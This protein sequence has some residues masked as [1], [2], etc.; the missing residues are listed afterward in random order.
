MLI[1]QPLIRERESFEKGRERGRGRE[2]KDVETVKK[3]RAEERE[4]EEAKPTKNY[5]QG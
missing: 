1:R 4:Q 2:R 3:E 5:K